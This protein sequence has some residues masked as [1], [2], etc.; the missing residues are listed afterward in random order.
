MHLVSHK[1][2]SSSLFYVTD[3]CS[4]FRFLVD[5]GAEVSVLPVG[6]HDKSN[7]GPHPLRA[8]NGSRISTYGQRSLTVDFGLRRVFR[9]VFVIADV[10]YPILGADFLYHFD[11]LVDTR[12]QQ[13]VD[14]ETGRS[15]TGTPTKDRALRAVF[16]GPNSEGKFASLLREF[17]QLTRP[18][19][20]LPA[21]TTEVLH[22]VVTH[23][24]PV[25]CRPRRLAPDRLKVARAEFEHMLELGIIRP[26][27]SPWA[28][29]QHMV[30]KK[31][32][33]DWRPCGDYRALNNVTTPDRYP[34]P[35]I[36]DLTAT[37][38][39]KRVFSKID[40]VRAYN[41]IPVA[42][43]DIPKTAVITP[44]GLFEFLRMPFGL[45]NAAQT[46]QRFMDQVCRGLDSVYVYL[47]DI[48][49]ASE[50]PEE[51][52]AHL[53]ALFDRLAQHGVTINPEK[54]SLGCD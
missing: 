2:Y 27:N 4:S 52:L 12:R 42:E 7:P 34:V 28:S 8:A 40:L 18:P 51:H 37:L 38:A 11:L 29:P 54:C 23:G 33:N 26:S 13:L 39:G 5:T 6:T 3:R 15:V 49:V 53:R 16:A 31:S 44:F 21:V 22:H 36:Q 30:P 9:W 20:S 17:P 10:P 43:S 48:L 19:S 32:A 45:R 50:T 35:H 46:F 41:Q 1:R 14:Q 24:P 47:D 25:R